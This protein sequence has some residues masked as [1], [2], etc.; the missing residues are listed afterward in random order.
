MAKISYIGATIAVAAGKPATTDAAGFA[1]LSYST[2]G[3]IQQFGAIGDTSAAIEVGDLA[4]GRI[5]RINGAV[6]GG[7]NEF[8]FSYEDADA[9]QVILRNNSNT[10]NDVSCRVTDP[11]GQIA[12]F[13]GRVANV[14]DKERTMDTDKGM[15]GTFRI[16][17]PIIR[18]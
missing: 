11:D 4:A 5:S 12:Y 8:S 1:A 10:N 9:G 3:E 16:N 2:V 6:D 15:T 17:S 14:R 13:F 18:A 7:E